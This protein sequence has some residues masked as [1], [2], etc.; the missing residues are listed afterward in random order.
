MFKSV[1]CAAVAAVGA[2][3]S[4]LVVHLHFADVLDLTIIVL[5]VL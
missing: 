4:A 2:A 3:A 5:F 1:V